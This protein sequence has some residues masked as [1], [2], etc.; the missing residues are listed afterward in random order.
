[1]AKVQDLNNNKDLNKMRKI[2]KP[3]ILMAGGAQCKE[4][5]MLRLQLGCQGYPYRDKVACF[6]MDV[7][8]FEEGAKAMK[9]KTDSIPQFISLYKEKTLDTQAGFN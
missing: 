3:V 5:N 6:Y 1:M 7:D 4:S 2:D 8:K 9:I